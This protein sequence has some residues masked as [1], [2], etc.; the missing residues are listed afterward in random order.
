[1]L[2][3]SL[4]IFDISAISTSNPD[5]FDD[6]GGYQFTP[7]VDTVTLSPGASTQTV[8]ILDSVDATFDDD[9]GSAQTLVND[10]T[11]GGTFF[12]YGTQIEAE[13]ILRVQDAQGTTYTLQMVSLEGDAFTI[14]GFTVQ[15]PLPPFGEALTIVDAQ[16]EVAGIYAYSTTTPTCFATN[17]RI[18]MANGTWRAAG[19]LRIGEAVRL[20]NGGT[21][22]IALLI[23]VQAPHPSSGAG[24]PIRIRSGALGAGVPRSDLVL[25]PQHRVYLPQ[26]TAL[27]PAR[28]L[29]G[30]PRIG[31]LPATGAQFRYVHIVLPDHGLLNAEGLICESFWPSPVALS[32]MPGPLA[33]RIRA[34][35]GPNP[36]RAAPFL[37]VQAAR[38]AMRQV[39]ET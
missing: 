23:H 17:A 38:K 36:V 24:R 19:A 12:P 28:A 2:S 16:D 6:N 33:A 14:H 26:M 29:T 30:L 9:P 39:A 31:H 20:A 18:E 10:T 34:I 35:L 27:V 1:M 7:W 22:Q 11:I 5:G 15:G 25:S 32:Q 21:A 4:N 3:Y 8:A 13:Y 37:S